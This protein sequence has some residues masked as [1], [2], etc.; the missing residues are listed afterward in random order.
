M[1]H[2]II[3]AG[4]VSPANIFVVNEEDAA[5]R[6][7]LCD[8]YGVCA[9]GP[10]SIKDAGIVFFGVKPQVFPAACEMY[11]K[12]FTAD[13]VYLTPMAGISSKAVSTAA[14]GGHVIRFM[15]NLALSV[16]ESA[17]GYALGDGCGER[18]RSIAK[19][20]FESLGVAKEIDESQMSAVTA[21][22]GSG[23][24][25]FYYLCE[26]MIEAAVADGM[27]GDT[28]RALAVQTFIGT[29]KLIE[30][31]GETPTEMRRRITSKKGTT[32]AAINAMEEEG[33]FGV[34]DAGYRAAR[35]RSDE[36]G[37]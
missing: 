20:L 27:D 21:L 5:G 15:P 30:D 2:G 25:Y 17:I 29:A 14:N 24:A 19:A 26:A 18:E 31:S 36:L 11:G 37:K 6:D 9:A 28:A 16:R 35:D 10:E 4:V 7:A 1:V 22:S 3:E 12:Y 34:V 13:K 8:K 33:F 32:E 23:P